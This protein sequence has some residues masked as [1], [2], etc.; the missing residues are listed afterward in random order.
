M[1]FLQ[2][3]YLLLQLLK[4]CFSLAH[5]RPLLT[6]DQLRHFSALALYGA[7]QLCED[8]LALLEGRLCGELRGDKSR[9][10]KRDFGFKE[11]MRRKTGSLLL[12]WSR[13][14]MYYADVLKLSELNPSRTFSET[15]VQ[16]QL[17]R[18]LYTALALRPCCITETLVRVTV[19][20]GT[21]LYT[22]TGF[23]AYY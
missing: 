15:K 4:E 7:H 18:N 13:S 12:F 10:I 16:K 2:L 6:P 3:C 11:V 8:A 9:M 17:F 20:A 21:H 5:C 22:C 1:S 23:R 19:K 14:L